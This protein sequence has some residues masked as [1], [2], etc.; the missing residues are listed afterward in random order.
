[1]P[2]RP[3]WIH[4]REKHGIYRTSGTVGH[5]S[6]ICWLVDVGDCKARNKKFRI[7]LK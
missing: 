3:N 6:E 1:M 4:E 5:G 7:V 2:M